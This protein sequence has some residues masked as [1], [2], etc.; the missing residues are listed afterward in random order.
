MDPVE[1]YLTDLKT[2][3]DKIDP[4]DYYLSYSGGRDSHFLLWFIKDILKDNRIKVVSV[5]TYLEH[6]EI[7]Q[8][9]IEHADVILKPS[10]KPFEI[11]DRYGIPCFSKMQDEMIDRYQKGSRTPSLMQFIHGTKNDGKTFFK[12]NRT[13][14]KLLLNDDLHRISNKCCYYMKK[15]P[16]KNY[17]KMTGKKPIL[18]VRAVESINRKAV[19]RTCFTGRSFTPI[20]DLTDEL[21]K[22][23]ERRYKIDIPA[24][25]DHIDR[26]GCMGCPY[27]SYHGDTEKELL[28]INKNQRNFVCELFKESY[29]ILGVKTDRDMK[30]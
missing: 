25:Y 22:A 7:K 12:L 11:K 21:L 13:A 29:Q 30:K 15:L 18:G 26:T 20:H 23:I 1:F 24:I 14:K 3:F 27:G 5:N 16:V 10:L 2:K 4:A 9:M 6:H 8:R 28:L 19:Y 17:E